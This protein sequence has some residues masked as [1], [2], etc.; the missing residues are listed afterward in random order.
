[1]FKSLVAKLP[2]DK[3]Y[4]QRQFVIN[5]L[6]KVVD[7]TMYDHLPYSFYTE[8]NEAGEYVK[9]ADRRPSS[10]SNLC[11]VVVDDSVSLLFSDGHFPTV[12]C[13]NDYTADQINL[14]I[15]E[16]KLN[17]VMIDA[18]TRGSVGSV[19]IFMKVLNN[20]V[21]FDSMGT[22]YL[23]PVWRDDAPDTLEVVK[24]RY[25][26]KGRVLRK[27]GYAIDEEMSAQD[28][29]FARDWNDKAETWYLPKLCSVVDIDSN[30]YVFPVDTVKTVNHNLGFVPIVWVKN[31]PNG[32]DIDGGCTF[33]VAVDT[34]IEIDYLMSQGSRGL[35]YSSDPMLVI[36]DS[37]SD[38]S[39]IVKGGGNALKVEPA[40]DAKLLE[41]NG[42]ASAAMTEWIKMLRESALESV[43][44]NRSNADKI[45]AAQSGKAMELMNQSLIWLADKLRISYGEGAL[46]ELLKMVVRVS[47]KQS[48]KIEGKDVKD[49][50][51]E[52]LC[53]KWP[54]WY[55]PTATDRQADATALNTLAS[56]GILSRQ[57]ATASIADEYD[58]EDV[59]AELVKIADESK[60]K[61]A[62]TQ[63]TL[64]NTLPIGGV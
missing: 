7:G 13:E 42:T 49:L 58:I 41:I 48:I 50:S 53:L 55:H 14:L 34:M 20:R 45:A 57:T 37:A 18:A 47:K 31:L 32:D 15:K 2:K 61:L 8:I 62:Q 11:R 30:D 21:F 26:V 46:L 59:Q 23:T 43:H 10:R 22:Q 38:D 24:E 36:K 12:G 4:P 27:Q 19:A 39:T 51:N 33:K 63:K 56:G 64:E 5:A 25:K 54:H 17:Q 52:S 40:G 28:F 35:R 9:L 44:G 1:M 60:V 6:T 3:D 29:W 16:T